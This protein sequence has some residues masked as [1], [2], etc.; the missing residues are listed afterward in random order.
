MSSP[1]WQFT[2]DA[3][4]VSQL[5]RRDIY[6]RDDVYLRELLQNA[7][8]AAA[9]MVTLELFAL[10]DA[11]EDVWGLRCC[12]DGSGMTENDIR[13]R[14]LNLCARKEPDRPQFARFGIGV[15]TYLSQAKVAAVATKADSER[16]YFFT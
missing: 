5:L 7:Y 16:G 15:F 8:D 14:F 10:P 11:H 6:T 12:D 3:A 13:A 2:I 9:T 4:G 1:R